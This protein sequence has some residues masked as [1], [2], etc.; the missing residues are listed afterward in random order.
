MEIR[1]QKWL[2]QSGVA[3]RRKAEELILSGLVA[4]NGKTVTNL[5]TRADTTKDTVTVS[6]K[7]VEIAT[8][9]IY[10][11]LHKPEGVITSVS[12]PHGRPTV[13]DL[14]PAELR[15]G[16]FPVGRLDYDTSG[17][18]VLT[19]DGE[20]A[21]RMTHPKHETKKTYIATI[22][23]LPGKESLEAF[24]RG[25]M[26]EGKRTAPATIEIIKREPDKTQVRIKLH[27]GRNR[28]V[29]KMCEAIGH[30]VLSLKRVEIGQ[31]KLGALPRGQW[32]RLQGNN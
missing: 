31:L 1:L 6:G 10:L 11:A 25:L 8:Q 14:I 15:P 23:G 18:I 7:A 32:R 27:E 4:V 24:C 17:L 9:K 19:N 3:S 28:Q 30:P 29:R 20:Y 13:M 2:S 26:I 22:K 21:Q 12:D 5:G 16:L